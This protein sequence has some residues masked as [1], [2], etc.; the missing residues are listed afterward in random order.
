MTV[1]DRN[2]GGVIMSVQVSTNI[3]EFT[4]AQFDSVCASMGV[5]PSNVLS[6]LIKGVVRCNGIPFDVAA[7]PQMKPKMSRESV[8]GCMRGQFK[9]AD[10]F[11]EPLDDFKEYME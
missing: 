7:Q 8:F 1:E 6:M 2:Y 11:D 9:M 5:T 4:K 10:D 3:D